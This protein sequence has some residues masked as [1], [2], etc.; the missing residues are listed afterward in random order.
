MV[1]LLHSI[2]YQ[3]ALTIQIKW[4]PEMPR[5]HCSSIPAMHLP[6]LS[7]DSDTAQSLLILWLC[8]L[9]HSTCGMATLM[10]GRFLACRWRKTTEN[11]ADGSLYRGLYYWGRAIGR[12][13]LLRRR[14]RIRDTVIRHCKVGSLKDII[15]RRGWCFTADLSRGPSSGFHALSLTQPTPSSRL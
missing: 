8:T 9:A 4:Q 12:Y 6:C 3:E 5:K 10:V 7:V 11:G 15:R 1:F 13:N 14:N 2:Q